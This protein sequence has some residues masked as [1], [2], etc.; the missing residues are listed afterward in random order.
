MQD[1]WDVS[2][3]ADSEFFLVDEFESTL[4]I[5]DA[6]N[7]GFEPWVACFD[8]ASLRLGFYSSEEVIECFAESVTYILEDLT[9]NFSDFWITNFEVNYEAVEVV[10]VSCPEFFV[11]SEKFVI[12]FFA[13]SK[14]I[15]KSSHLFCGGVQ[16]IFIHSQFHTVSEMEGFI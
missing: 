14:I 2:Y 6:T 12:G 15:E 5:G 1:D 16:P 9:V 13:E 8:F 10:F 11:E 7:F 3:F 4:W